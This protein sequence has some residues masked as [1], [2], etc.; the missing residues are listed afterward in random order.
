MIGTGGL[1]VVSKRH[2][3]GEIGYLLDPAYW[4]H[5]FATEAARLLLEFGFTR[6]QLHRMEADTEPDNVASRR[7]L[8]KIGMRYEGCGRHTSLIRGV[9]RDSARYAALAGEVA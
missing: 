7:V 9:W 1:N 6:L 8:E 5:G 2:Q 3:C 4:G